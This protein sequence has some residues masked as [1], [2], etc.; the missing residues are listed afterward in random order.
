MRFGSGLAKPGETLLARHLIM[1]SLP[2]FS[3]GRHQRISVV[4]HSPAAPQNHS[5][6]RARP[7]PAVSFQAD[8]GAGSPLPLGARCSAGNRTGYR[9]SKPPQTAG[10]AFVE[11]PQ[12]EQISAVPLESNQCLPAA[13]EGLRQPPS[14]H[15]SLQRVLTLQKKRPARFVPEVQTGEQR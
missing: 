9:Q 10:R 4:P 14:L 3:H 5:P 2:G 1:K 7:H 15:P 11:P 8:P 12:E 6:F 13:E